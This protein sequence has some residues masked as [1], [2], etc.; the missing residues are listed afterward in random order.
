MNEVFPVPLILVS[1]CLG[2]ATCRYDGQTLTD[3]FVEQ[4][5]LHA[6]MIPICPEVDCGL[7]IPRPPIRLCRAEGGIVVHQPAT[8]KDL[9]AQLRSAIDGI[10][11]ALPEIDGAILK[12]K[13][14]SCGLY[15]TKIYEGVD[16]P[17]V[18]KRSS[19]VFGEAVLRIF[20][21]QA[22]EDDLRLT[23]VKLREHFLIKLFTLAR[24]REI[25]ARPEMGRLVDFHAVH[26]LLLLA[27]NQ[28]RYRLAGRI[29]ANH[30]QF[31]AA[32]VFRLYRE[33]LC[34]IL[35]APLRVPAVINSL[36]HAL[37]WISEHLNGEEKKEVINSIEEYRDERLPLPAVTRLLEAHAA[38]L[39]HGYLH[40]QIF[41][42]PYPLALAHLTG[43]GPDLEVA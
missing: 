3:A 41:L 43:S 20:A 40:S 37:G 12:N 35:H 5:Q 31:P 34:R 2:F 18:L 30:P 17:Q 22:I 28:S 32:E 29:A 9:T 13:S 27:C 15:D 25:S 33:E 23:D 11:K 14:P 21:G 8:G 36:Y 6:E 42:R 1:R 24:F 10:I 26:K 7:G 19:G 38:R 16:R 39:D 4:L